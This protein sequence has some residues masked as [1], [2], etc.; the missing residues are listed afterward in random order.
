MEAKIKKEL[1]IDVR[2]IEGSNGVFD[3]FFNSEFIFSKDKEGRF[4]AD[5]EIIK[6]L[7]I[8]M[9]SKN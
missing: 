2:L 3:I 4:P 9:Q 1:A 6:F 5:E 7:R 8:A